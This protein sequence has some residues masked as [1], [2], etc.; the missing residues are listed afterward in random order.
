[1]RSLKVLTGE[2]ETAEKIVS[3]LQKFAAVT[4]FTST[5]LI[6]TSKR[7][8]AFGVE[9]DKL[10]ETTQRLADVSGATG[11]ELNGVA[12]AYGQIVAKGRLQGE[13]LLQLQERGIGI[14]EELQKMYGLSG[15]EFR[16]ALEKGQI[17]AEAVELAIKRLTESGGKYADGAISQSDTLAGKFST[18]QDGIENLAR[19]I[20]NVLSPAIK[21]ILN[22]AIDAINIINK[23]LN[24][25]NKAS[26][27]GLDQTAQKGILDQARREAEEIVNLRNI[28]D[29]FE[30]N[31]VFQ[32]IAAQRESDL[33][34]AYGFKTGKLQVEIELVDPNDSKIPDLLNN[35]KNTNTGG[36]S[37][38]DTLKQQ[39]EAGKELAQ[40]FERN[41][42]LREAEN[43]LAKDLLQV[44]FDRI[45]AIEQIKETAAENQQATLIEL[46]NAEALAE[47]EQ[48]RADAFKEQQ[49]AREDALQPL[50]DQK[51]YLQ[52]I[53]QFGEDEAAIR[54]RINEIEGASA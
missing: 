41:R 30:R 31:K 14:Q 26:K 44:E 16:K 32:Q 40:Q 12:T 21:I 34:D 38:A 50:I 20:G 24:S 9:T 42:Q 36:S 10:V 51:S 1:M 18:L 52:D 4:P 43:Q 8:A 33:L 22:E 5:E 29:P 53:L 11:A 48:L 25:A 2:L 27:F 35:N 15:E 54:Q 17:S 23:L 39:L 3:R 46:A 13:E 19:T 28:Q 6:E 37:A 45:D 49:K 7:L 47:S